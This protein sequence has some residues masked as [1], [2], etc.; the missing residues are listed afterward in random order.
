VWLLM[1]RTQWRSPEFWLIALSACGRR[2]AVMT[3]ELMTSI[4]TRF[5]GHLV[6]LKRLTAREG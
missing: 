4:M 1:I 6:G 3:I 5:I 2:A